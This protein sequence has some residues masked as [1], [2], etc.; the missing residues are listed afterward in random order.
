MKENVLDILMYLF[1]HCVDNDSGTMP[2]I[3]SVRDDLGYA[4]FQHG[5]I[6][7]A[8]AWLEGLSV[9]RENTIKYSAVS[10]SANSIRIF[11]RQECNKLDLECRGF[12]LFLEQSGILDPV[13]R[14]LVIDRAMALEGNEIDLT[15]LKWVI[16]MILFNQPGQEAAYAWMEDLI[17]EEV[18][19]QIH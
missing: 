15:H 8:F 17:F 11:T 5:D 7:K 19:E 2:D 12:M 3:E 14:E 4:G 9:A 6:D 13:S 16:L 18:A 10:K 1:E